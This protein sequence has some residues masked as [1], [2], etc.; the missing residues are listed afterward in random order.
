MEQK[1][2]FLN[3]NLSA[4]LSR[5]QM[6]EY[7]MTP[8]ELEEQTLL[9]QKAEVII[10]DPEKSINAEDLINRSVK[11]S[12]VDAST[13]KQ[14]TEGT[15]DELLKMLPTL[16]SAAS[17]TLLPSAILIAGWKLIDNGNYDGWVAILK[18]LRYVPLQIAFCYE[19]KRHN[20]YYLMLKSLDSK[21]LDYPRSFLMLLFDHWF[22]WI[23][24]V[25]NNLLSYED[26]RENYAKNE[27]AQPLK[28][29]GLA[30]KAEWESELPTMIHE[31]VAAFSP[32][33]NAE[34]LLAHATRKYLRNDTLFN[35]YSSNFNLCLELLWSELSLSATFE[36]VADKDLNLNMI[37]LMVNKAV[38][39][40]DQIL[41]R[42]VYDKLLFC[43][44]NNN[45]SG[46]E[47]DSPIDEKRQREIAELILLIN[48]SLDFTQD[49]VRVATRF[50]GWNIDYKQVYNEA[51]REAYLMCSLF[52][53]F[54]IR[55]FN[56][57][58]L[59]THWKILLDICL[60]E[61]QRCD[62]E[63]ILY[64]EFNVPFCIAAKIAEQLNNDNCREYLHDI[65]VSNVL[66]IVSLLK[67]FL[68]CNI[69]L[70]EETI[71]RLIQRIE[72]E[73]P[74]AAMLMNVRGQSTL[75]SRIEAFIEHI[76][77]QSTSR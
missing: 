2:L 18:A 41:G 55:K 42:K 58:T 44:L 10:R 72:V 75:K 24:Q 29:E 43:L 28:K 69:R 14:I 23:T 34:M 6:G 37:M 64:D 35:P 51:R 68:G 17:M 26:V 21:T 15:D 3:N 27:R 46:M 30:I 65:V 70:S 50:Q 56:D 54:E 5:Q 16:E 66:N 77:L 11:F 71:K 67:V 40:G 52:R 19:M 12:H 53:V 1:D 13:L 60:W 59:F 61:Y 62:N 39:N 57:G 31:I 7:V 74:S 47:K 36:N 22:E 25:G 32:H 4:M 73:W 9:Q 45:F 63:Y 20:D 48:P 38:T 33:L 76:K 8:E 49:V